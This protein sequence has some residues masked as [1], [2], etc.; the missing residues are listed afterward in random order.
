MLKTTKLTK[1]YKKQTAINELNLEITKPGLYIF[2]GANGSGKSTF[3]NLISGLILPDRG[4]I[5]INEKSDANNR[6]LQIGISNEPFYTEPS[7]TVNEISD[8]CLNIKK[9]SPETANQWLSFWEL[10]PVRDKPFNALSTGMKKRLSLALSL[11]AN[12]QILLWDEPFNGLDP[13]GIKL[14]NEL[15]YQLKEQ[16]KYILIS[17]HLLNE[18]SIKEAN[19]FV[20]KDGLLIGTISENSCPNPN[21]AI[22]N[23]LKS[24]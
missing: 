9:A 19:Y 16:G 20:L 4:E 12:P 23:L 13:L 11:Y 22:I 15:I 18:I 5:R 24:N 1:S 2:V 7:L 14:L 17:T 3:F 10:D 8:I 21:E 6:R